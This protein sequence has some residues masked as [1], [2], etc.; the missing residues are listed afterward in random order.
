MSREREREKTKEEAG[1]F[2]S[3]FYFTIKSM[4]TYVVHASSKSG[5]TFF[6]TFR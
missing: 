1:G 6:L 4:V 3:W 5:M 2:V